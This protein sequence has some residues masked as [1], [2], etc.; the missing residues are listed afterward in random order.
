MRKEKLRE[1]IKTVLALKTS[2]WLYLWPSVCNMCLHPVPERSVHIKGPFAQRTCL[3]GGASR[4][5]WICRWAFLFALISLSSFPSLWLSSVST[6]RSNK[7]TRNE[8]ERERE[9]V[10]MWVRA[11]AAEARSFGKKILCIFNALHRRARVR[12]HMEQI[13]SIGTRCRLFV[14]LIFERASYPD[15]PLRVRR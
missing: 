7:Y 12:V 3:E 11:S 2:A 10:C 15:P 13:S 8:R 9:C 1:L 6:V 14:F 4:S 5:R